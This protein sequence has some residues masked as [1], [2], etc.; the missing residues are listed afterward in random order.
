MISPSQHQGE[1]MGG[2]GFLCPDTGNEL[3]S[4]SEFRP[5]R[6]HL[7]WSDCGWLTGNPCLL[8]QDDTNW[9]TVGTPINIV[10]IED[11]QCTEADWKRSTSWKGPPT[12]LGVKVGASNIWAWMVNNLCSWDDLDTGFT[13]DI[14]QFLKNSKCQVPECLSLTEA[15]GF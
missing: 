14:Y 11:D 8:F 2:L 9:Q 3:I 5:F 7:K 4:G 10:F 1:E 13:L 12:L 15:R 6:Q